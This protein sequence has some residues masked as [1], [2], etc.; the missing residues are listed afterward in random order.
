[1]ISRAENLIMNHTGLNSCDTELK[2]TAVN[3]AKL[4]IQTSKAKK[5]LRRKGIE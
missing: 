5:G 2:E 1:M 4:K 3:I